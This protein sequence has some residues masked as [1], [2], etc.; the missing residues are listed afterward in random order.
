MENKYYGRERICKS[1]MDLD[2]KGKTL[3]IGAGEVIWIEN[4][5][6]LN[7][8]NFISS[9]IDKKNLGEKNKAKNKVVADATKSSNNIRCFR[10]YKRS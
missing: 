6:F 9:D 4:D 1:F 5:L 10:T 2:E 7:N 8:K 3:N